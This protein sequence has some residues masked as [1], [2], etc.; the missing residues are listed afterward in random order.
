MTDLPMTIGVLV[1]A[2]LLGSIPFGLVLSRMAGLGDIRDIGSG[3]IG[4]TNVLRTGNKFIAALTLLTDAA[5]GFIAV[6]IALELLGMST[7][8]W[9]GLAALLGHV[10]PVWL[11]FKGG[12]G[13]AVFI[14]TS[15]ALSP[16]P[17]LSF[18][19]VWLL[20]ALITRRSSLA[21]LIAAISVPLYMFLLGEVYGAAVV[22]VQVVL[23]YLAHREN[24]F[25]LL[26]GEEPRI[27]QSA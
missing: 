16:L 26:S 2:Y 6:A 21:A 23:V 24:I 3:N 25:R 1:L 18:L 22:G 12:K 15:I 4:A 17:G 14:G 5:K 7:A 11:G 8:Y 19:T 20:V 9:A 13:V 10:F 27:G